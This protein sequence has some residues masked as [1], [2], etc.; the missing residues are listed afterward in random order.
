MIN[1]DEIFG[2]EDAIAHTPS[3]EARKQEEK[4]QEQEP[5]QEGQKASV[6]YRYRQSIGKVGDVRIRI[7]PGS[8]KPLPMVW[9]DARWRLM[10]IDAK[11]KHAE[12][13]C[14]GLPGAYSARAVDSCASLLVPILENLNAVLTTTTRHIISTAN[15]NLEILQD[16][17]IEVL[18]HDR[19]LY[20]PVFVNVN[21]PEG[22]I[23]SE[24]DPEKSARRKFLR[25]PGSGEIEA[26]KT[27][28]SSLITG[29]MTRKDE[30]AVFQEFFGQPLTRVK[31]QTIAVLQGEPGRGK[32]Q[33]MNVLAGLI[34]NSATINFSSVGKYDLGQ[35]V[36]A[37][38]IVGDEIRGRFNETLFKQ[39]TG[40]SF[41][42][43]ERK[44]E[45]PF[46][47][48]IE[49]SVMIGWNNPPRIGEHSSA[50]EQRMVIFLCD[51][52]LKRGTKDEKDDLSRRV[53]D[54]DK[55]DVLLWALQGAVR[56]V[57]RGTLLTREELPLRL[58]REREK[59]GTQTDPIRAFVNE[60][61]IGP[62]VDTYYAK[63][64]VYKAFC[65]WLRKEG[66]MP[67]APMSKDVA[68]KHLKRCIEN[69]HGAGCLGGELKVTAI[70]DGA[71][72]R[73]Y[74]MRLNFGNPG[75][76][77]PLNR[78]DTISAMSRFESYEEGEAP[79]HLVALE[80]EK[81]RHKLEL[82]QAS[83]KERQAVLERQAK[84]LK[85]KEEREMLAQGFVRSVCGLTGKP[86]WE[87]KV[88]K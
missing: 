24:K 53:L 65:E 71:K 47:Y 20:V 31:A 15:C 28:F 66:R 68:I 51:G 11:R 35:L 32:S 80:E 72:S 83:A 70:R 4:A 29:L 27:L 81:R 77:L 14:A 33:V 10:D 42:T 22:L 19:N 61:E 43:I 8:G 26:K 36:G 16:G 57:S 48:S 67:G 39:V 56:V 88:S 52:P 40:R 62:S 73:V 6:E 3:Q 69:A 76:L 50:I 87:R 30:L 64:D 37:P 79:E 55:L 86:V 13:F 2:G 59:F 58:R 74:A 60:L 41:I 34:E 21:I 45:N 44:W 5:K 18:P 54:E 84:E 12:R 82:E 25:L 38:F 49:G 75:R 23:E 78:N 7:E 85:D 46:S 17:R 1:G 9:Q 63:D